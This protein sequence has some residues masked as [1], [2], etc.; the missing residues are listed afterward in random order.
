MNLLGRCGSPLHGARLSRTTS[1][2][3]VLVPIALPDN[4]GEQTNF[5]HHGLEDADLELAVFRLAIAQL[6]P[7]FRGQPLITESQK[8]CSCAMGRDGH[9][10]QVS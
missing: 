9:S 6:E 10:Q 7:V 3:Q 8:E 1:Q 2:A 4:F 5:C